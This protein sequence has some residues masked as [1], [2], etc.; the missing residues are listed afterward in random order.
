[1]A[2]YD[3]DWPNRYYRP[4][5]ATRPDLNSE[6][7]LNNIARQNPTLLTAVARY[8][9]KA[10]WRFTSQQLD[11]LLRGDLGSG[12]QLEVLRKLTRTVASEEARALLHRLREV[13]GNFGLEQVTVVAAAGP[14]IEAAL[15]KLL[16][17]EGLW[18]QKGRD[19]RFVL[20]P[21]VSQL[22]SLELPEPT[23]REINGALAEQILDKGT[24]DQYDIHR[25][26]LYLVKAEEFNRAGWLLTV[27]LNYAIENYPTNPAYE[28]SLLFQHMWIGMPLPNEMDLDL[29]LYIRFRQMELRKLKGEST[30]YLLGDMKRLISGSPTNNVL[31]NYTRAVIAPTIAKQDFSQA[32]EYVK[33]FVANAPTLAFADGTKVA[34]LP[35]AVN[36]HPNLVGVVEEVD[37]EAFV[38]TN[39]YLSAK[40]PWLIALEASSPEDV[41]KWLDIFAAMSPEQREA[42][43][44]DQTAVEGWRIMADKIW[45]YEHDKP[46]SERDWD[47]CLATLGRLAEQAKVLHLEVLWA[48]ATADKLAVLNEYLGRLSD[49]EETARAALDEASGDPRVAFALESQMGFQFKIAKE[50]DRALPWLERAS[51]HEFI[52]HIS[53]K[54]YNQLHL[55]HIYGRQGDHE[56]AVRHARA[57]VDLA[58]TLGETPGT[59]LCRC[60]GEL[61]LAL[62]QSGRPGEAFAAANEA[63][64]II[65]NARDDTNEWKTVFVLLGA[66]VAHVSL[67]D[68]FSARL[69]TKFAEVG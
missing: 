6:L 65:L 15:E 53:E 64:Q 62:K 42:L 51:K 9:S 24:L 20:S 16:E 48:W 60:L 18:V 2:N 61:A 69:C 44:E 17:L 58:R 23:T 33:E 55:S 31:A 14:R 28:D 32:V 46:S 10:G 45:F 66:V 57:A 35:T 68:K 59:F 38:E 47:A 50:Y 30:E 12:T 43:S 63:G 11:D 13:M 67:G 40:V 3:I 4:G 22:N 27:G 56:A 8:L 34:E 7:R 1:L 37:V 49:A 41:F 19:E 36:S 39:E 5:A 54:A 25:G 52:G 26:V 29:R 21:L